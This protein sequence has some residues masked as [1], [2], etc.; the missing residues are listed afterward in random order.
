MPYKKYIKDTIIIFVSLLSIGVF[1]NTSHAEK[2]KSRKPFSSHVDTK[3]NISL[4]A[5]FRLTMVHLGSWYVPEGDASGF[6]DVYADPKSVIEYRLT[7]KWRDGAA[8]V[9]ELRGATSGQYTT[10][11]NV[12]HANDHI[13]QWFVMIKDTTNRFPKN[14]NWGNGWG[15]ALVKPDDINKNLS[16]NYKTDCLGCHVPA[17]KTDWIY[18]EG[19]PTLISNK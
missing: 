9:K 2:S 8:I 12:A 15:W 4:P 18:I 1:S 14:S 5:D 13:K 10:G 11:P 7:G 16:T 6:H 19:M 3:G 17:Q